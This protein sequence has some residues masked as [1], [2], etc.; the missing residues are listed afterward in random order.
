VILHGDARR[1][2]KTLPDASVHVCVTSPP[3]YWQRDYQHPDQIG[4]EPTVDAYVDAL[5]EVFAEVQRVLVP[6]GTLWLNLG[7]TYN[8][9]N[10]NRGPS[11]S[12]SSRSDQHRPSAPRGLLDPTAKNK[13]LLGVPWRAALR[14]RDEQGWYLRAPVVWIR[15]RPERVRDRPR[16]GYE[17][18]FQ[19]VR[20]QRG[21][22][23][24]Q[25]VPGAGDAIWTLNGHTDHEHDAAYPVS[26]PRRCIAISS[27]VSDT[28]LDPFAGSGTTERAAHE[29]ERSFIGCDIN[30]TNGHLN[31]EVLR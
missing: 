16:Q 9:Y 30:Y 26:L 28:V 24:N 1:S 19:L 8:A 15:H 20:S 7:D 25:D 17:M 22:T 29:L 5:L 14:L 2:L 4:L 3:Y 11:Q 27:N 18:I 6:T 10:G 31:Q 12:I 23:Y 13:D 21:V